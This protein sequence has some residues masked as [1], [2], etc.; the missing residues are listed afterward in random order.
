MRRGTQITE[1][2]LKDV[3]QRIVH[4]IR[5]WDIAQRLVEKVKRYWET[6]NERDDLSL[7]ESHAIYRQ[8]DYGD[9]VPL[10]K[11]RRLDIGWSDHAEYRSDLRDVPHQ[12]VNQG[13]VDWLR[14]RLMTKGP[15]KKKVRMKLPGKGTA[16]VDYDLTKNPSDAEI[17]TVWASSKTAGGV[18]TEDEYIMSKGVEVFPPGEPGLHRT[19]R[20]IPKSQQRENAKMMLKRQDDW[21]KQVDA[22]R[23]EYRQKVMDGEIRPPSR[24]E[25]LMDTAKGHPDN[26]SVQAARRILRKQGLWDDQLEEETDARFASSS[27]TAVDY[28]P[29]TLAA[30]VERLYRRIHLSHEEDI[31]AFQTKHRMPTDR[32]LGTRVHPDKKKFQKTQRQKEKQKLRRDYNQD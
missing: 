22:L 8:E 6:R 23:E 31:T 2:N 15:D 12:E 4:N 28:G 26:P 17:I 24:I 1:A 9:S 10:S 27:R 32:N 18:M 13:I 7:D 16:V 30:L 20:R 25:R 5:D 11:K 29:P 19:P 21:Q 14:E 3:A